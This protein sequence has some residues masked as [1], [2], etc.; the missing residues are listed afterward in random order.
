MGSIGHGQNGAINLDKAG[1]GTCADAPPLLP[2]N[3]LSTV[4]E[5]ITRNCT[6]ETDASFN[7]V[8]YL[9]SVFCR[10]C[11]DEEEDCVH[12]GHFVEP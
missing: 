5:V 3:K 10:S 6:I 1:L 4:I 8:G 2:K 11:G 9:A 12:I 7:G